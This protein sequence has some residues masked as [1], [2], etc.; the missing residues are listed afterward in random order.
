MTEILIYGEIGWDVTPK[1]VVEQLN[2]TDG[3]VTVR[4]DSY[5]GDVYAGIAIMNA[6]RRHADTVTVVVDGMAAS[7]AS[8]IAVGG[9]DRVVMSPNSSMMV[10]GAWTFAD[11][12]A[13]KLSE[14]A[15]DLA[16]ITEN[17]AGIYGEKS[18]QSSE[19]WLAV[20]EKDTTYSA[21]EA[22]EAGLADEVATLEKSAF[23]AQRQQ[24]LASGDGQKRRR[25]G[26]GVPT[27]A[28]RA[29]APS[30]PVASRSESAATPTKPSDGQNGDKMNVLNQLAQELGKKPEEVRDA[31]SGFFNE[32][33]EVS[34][35][36][37]VTYPEGL[38]I[39]PTERI[40][41]EPVIAE[42][43]PDAEQSSEPQNLAAPALAASLQFEMG[44]IAEGFT[45]ECDADGKVTI[46]APSG[47]EVGATAEFTVLVNGAAVPLTVTVRS[48]SEEPAT[49][50]DS[51][52]PAAPAPTA[53]A[54][55]VQ[56]PR[57]HF[58]YLNEIAANFGK[59]QSELEAKVRAER[60]DQDIKD[61]RFAAANRQV[62]LD[63]LTR[64]PSA[65]DESWGRMPK[66][67]IPVVEMGNAGEP[68]S[69]VEELLAK[70]R[71]NRTHKKGA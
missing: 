3:P 54:D 17:I 10:H 13:T 40:V 46:T 38:T 42:Q 2:G 1:A 65:Y 26:S 29:T 57:A 20:M 18:G 19:Y 47:A 6:L 23:A 24:V 33:V 5:G 32:A 59:A 64:N 30:Q 67:T 66:N 4:I 62:A 44:E 41:V 49:S 51:E 68:Q 12:N 25:F 21:D 31:L 9:G 69:R 71:A 37:E 52:A 50:E 34:G 16:K 36:V 56:V 53:G 8:F 28:P 27:I 60:V 11:G 63:T 58:D 22:V 55:I 48:L 14:V 45:A 15:D 39:V 7:A 35:E 70:A 61:G 43:A